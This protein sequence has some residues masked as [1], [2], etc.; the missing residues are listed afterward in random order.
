MN[1]T[2]E[3]RSHAELVGLVEIAKAKLREQTE[4]FDWAQSYV[5]SA[6]WAGHPLSDAVKTEL[7][8]RDR[9]LWETANAL[10]WL[11]SFVGQMTTHEFWQYVVKHAPRVPL[12]E[13]LVEK[14]VSEC[15]A[16]LSRVPEALRTNHGTPPPDII[17]VHPCSSVVENSPVPPPTL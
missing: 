2:L 14:C 3:N 1:A 16:A 6:R 9:Q 5:N 7:M 11:L 17:R 13:A 12:E 4:F 15:W 10:G 8:E